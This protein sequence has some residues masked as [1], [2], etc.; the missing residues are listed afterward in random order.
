MTQEELANI[1][2]KPCSIPIKKYGHE[3]MTRATVHPKLKTVEELIPGSRQYVNLGCGDIILPGWL[4][5]D[6]FIES[7][8]IYNWEL[9]YLKMNDESA[10]ILYSCHSLEHVSLYKAFECL[11]EWHRVLKPDGILYLTVPDIDK[12]VELFHQDSNW[13]L[14]CLYGMQ[15]GPG[16]IHMYG[17]TENHIKK[18]LE[19]TGFKITFFD[20]YFYGEAPSFWLEATK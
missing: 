12:S 13:F 16:H 20:K 4:N 6:Y 15:T 18:L 3:V 9:S 2:L 10:D 17:Y 7:P 8:K 19:M 5:V 14:K 1:F 11:K